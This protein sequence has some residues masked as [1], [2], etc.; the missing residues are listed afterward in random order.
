MHKC[1]R[2]YALHGTR[3]PAGLR[4]APVYVAYARVRRKKY[5]INC[6]SRYLWCNPRVYF[7]Y[8]TGTSEM[9]SLAR[10]GGEPIVNSQPPRKFE[11]VSRKEAINMA[12]HLTRPWREL[13][14]EA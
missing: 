4:L 7:Q 1:M 9:E 3:L 13:I 11:N 10:E 5:F 2:I 8:W 14:S 6:I 12:Y